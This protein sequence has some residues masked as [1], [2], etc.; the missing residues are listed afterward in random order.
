MHLELVQD[1]MMK[2]VCLRSEMERE[3]RSAVCGDILAPQ[4]VQGTQSVQELQHPLL[5]FLWIEA[6]GGQRPAVPRHALEEVDEERQVV[7]RVRGHVACA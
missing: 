5:A 1:Q 2:H 6:L 7:A 3:L 4:A